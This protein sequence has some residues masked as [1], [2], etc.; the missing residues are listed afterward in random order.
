[1][2]ELKELFESL[3][4]W[5]EVLFPLAVFLVLFLARYVTQF[6]KAGRLRDLAPFLNG[7]VV[8]RPFSPP[9][10]QG[11]YMGMPYQL[12]FVSE[13]RNMPGRLVV[14]LGFPFPFA[15]E[16]QPKDRFQGIARILRGSASSYETGDEVFDS[17]L[18]V[19]LS[20][21]RESAEVYL[22]NIENRRNLLNAFQEGF[23]SA[24][25][26]SSGIL[27]VR[28]G[29]FLATGLA[30]EQALRDLATAGRLAQRV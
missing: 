17:L 27:L 29:N 28:Q 5:L 10:I 4:G 24:S 14:K 23:V 19:R 20:R 9:R 1:M 21:A 30:P 13:S 25:F 16:I 15:M 26:G 6:F 3:R 8:L 12:S 22:D 7:E 2:S 18:S 11:T